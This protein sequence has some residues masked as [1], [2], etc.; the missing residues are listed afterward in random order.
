MQIVDAIC[1][2]IYDK[3][4]PHEQIGRKSYKEIVPF[5]EDIAV[6]DGCYDIDTVKRKNEFR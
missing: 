4:Q 5:V 2:I 6:Y 3:M 1:Q